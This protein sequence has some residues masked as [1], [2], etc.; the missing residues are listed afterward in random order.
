MTVK[1]QAKEIIDSLSNEASMD[2]VMHALYVNAKFEHGQQEIRE[3]QGIPHSQAKERLAKKDTTDVLRE[4]DD[5][6]KRSNAKVLCRIN[7]MVLCVMLGLMLAFGIYSHFRPELREFR[8]LAFFGSSLG[9]LFISNMVIGSFYKNAR[10]KPTVV[11]RVG[12]EQKPA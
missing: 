7:K 8:L 11:K 3:G 9:C 2:D 1:E 6:T 4:I 12:P 5:A 10:Y